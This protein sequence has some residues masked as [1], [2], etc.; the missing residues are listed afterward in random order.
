M[1]DI[2]EDTFLF[3]LVQFQ[4][5]QGVSCETCVPKT[6]QGLIPARAPKGFPLRRL[7]PASAHGRRSTGGAHR[8]LG[9]SDPWR[10]V[11]PLSHP[12]ALNGDYLSTPF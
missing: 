10:L 5:L 6:V 9:R 2:Q 12:Q 7:A 8:S 1:P 4:V 11:V 3:H